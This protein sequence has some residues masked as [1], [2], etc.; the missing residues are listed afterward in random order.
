[1]GNLDPPDP[2]R[3][4]KLVLEALIADGMDP[5]PSSSSI[6]KHHHLQLRSSLYCLSFLICCGHIF[7]PY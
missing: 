3:L 1:M 2:K 4:P 7:I 6:I 5:V